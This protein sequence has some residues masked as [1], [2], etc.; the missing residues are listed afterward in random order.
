MTHDQFSFYLS[1]LGAA[2]G[3]SDKQID[4]LLDIYYERISRSLDSEQMIKVTDWFLSNN[5]RFPTIKE[6]LIVG[7]MFPKV[8][9]IKEFS[10][11]STC[12]G[13][14]IVRTSK[15]NYKQLWKCG[16]CDNCNYNYPV[17]NADF[18]LRGYRKE[19]APTWDASDE[20]LIKG[21]AYLGEES[22]AW[23]KATIECRDAAIAY[24]QNFKSNVRPVAG[25]STIAQ[26]LSGRSDPDK[27]RERH[28]HI[29][30]VER[31]ERAAIQAEACE[32]YDIL[33]KVRY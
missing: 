20:M 12:W 14:G 7:Q 13:D 17:W 26:S 3:K 18:L 15:D 23:K 27:E 2:F 30:W 10:S 22:I 24:K 21:L 29:D 6:F 28:R 19:L 1:K 8:K 25:F 4:N 16:D 31:E 11:C 32:T 5:E 33:G 9:E